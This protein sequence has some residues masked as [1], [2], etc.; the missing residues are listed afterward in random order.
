MS[1]TRFMTLMFS[2]TDKEDEELL[3]QVHGDIESAKTN[4]SFEDEEMSYKD[5]GNGQVLA[6]DKGTNE[7]TMIHTETG[8]S[9][10][11]EL[12]EVPDYCVEGYLHPE[13]VPDG[14]AVVNPMVEEDKP[15]EKDQ[16][17]FSVVTDNTAVIKIFSDQDLVETVTESVSKSEQDA[18]VGDLKFEK[19]SDE[20]G[21]IVTDVT[22]GD[23]ARV[24][25]DGP[26][27]KVTELDQKNFKSFSN[28]SNKDMNV[29]RRKVYSNAEQ[30]E[31]IFVVGIDPINKVLVNSPVY[32]EVA[33]NELA[34]KLTSLGLV[35]VSIFAD[36]DQGRD[37]AL[38]LLTG[39]GAEE[40]AEAEEMQVAYSDNTV[41]A[42]R[43]FSDRTRFMNRLFSEA[44]EGISDA[45][46]EI[47]DAIK[48]GD[49]LETENEIITPV[50]G[51]SAVVEDK[52]T[53]EF[54]SVELV[55]DSMNVDQITEDKAQE[56]MK[57]VTV[58]DET[59][60]EFS[61]NEAPR[62]RMWSKI[63]T[64]KEPTRR[65]VLKTKNNS[66]V[67]AV[68]TPVEEK[69]TLAQIEDTS[70]QAIQNVQEAAETAIEAIEEA[71]QEP[72]EQPGDIQEASYSDK[73]F[74][75]A[76]GCKPLTSIRW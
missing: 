31:P 55:G 45:Q 32:G 30:Y 4:G 59:E 34:E 42:N 18:Q 66:D 57:D 11:V 44:D 68:E 6:T 56:L 22:S 49:Q 7:H 43:Y 64:P 12:E 54:T 25:L 27:M 23:K 24:V 65:S 41:V 2:A 33:A 21:V 13:V 36:P 50:G 62:E 26:E 9:E 60:K 70:V 5:L 8:D 37:Y 73:L 53:G 76:E 71:K 15:E 40:V 67:E 16:K 20:E 39:E 14:S 35:G 51:N 74:S 1:K 19:D 3:N 69:D 63:E 17:E 75:E 38:G 46:D 29:I 72:V 10:L 61:E 47:E 28:R 58:A 52:D 48:S